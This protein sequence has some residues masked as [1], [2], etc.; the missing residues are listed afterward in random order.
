MKKNIGSTDRLVRVL[1]A[2]TLT[3]LFVVGAFS[4]W[5]AVLVGFAV[6][7]L[8]VTS[9]NRFCPIYPIFRISTLKSTDEEVDA[10]VIE[11]A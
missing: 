11:S 4:G 3:I 8:L 2:L 7:M 6:F 1:L 9:S 5:W 10:E